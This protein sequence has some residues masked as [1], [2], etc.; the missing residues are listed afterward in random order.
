[1]PNT[2]VKTLTGDYGNVDADAND[3]EH[4]VVKEEKM[5]LR[6]AD[7]GAAAEKHLLFRTQTA[8]EV[9]GLDIISNTAVTGG[10]NDPEIDLTYNDGAGGAH[11]TVGQF[12]DF[13]AGTPSDL[14]ADTVVSTAVA[15]VAI[16]KGKYVWVF[17][18]VN[19]TPADMGEGGT[20][21]FI[22]RYVLAN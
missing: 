10:A 8:I 9:V 17:V 7:C 15:N 5:T 22:V 2:L 1:M 12:I 3:I 18:D 6:M 13:A 16:A 19:G 21:T 4:V 14:V 11:T 20:M